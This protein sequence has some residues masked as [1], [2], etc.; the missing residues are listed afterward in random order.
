MN[1]QTIKLILFAVAAGLIISVTYRYVEGRH[2]VEENELLKEDISKGN[3]D[4][5]ASLDLGLKL[6]EKVEE[7]GKRTQPIDIELDRASGLPV[8]DA[9]G[10]RRSEARI[11]AGVAARERAVQMP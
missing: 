11:R 9:D 2:A 1:M 8:F 4:N 7:Y 10:V 6:N 3:A 5:R